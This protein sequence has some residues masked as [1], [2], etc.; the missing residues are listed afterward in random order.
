MSKEY[1]SYRFFIM[2]YV[3]VIGNF[4]LLISEGANYYIWFLTSIT[5]LGTLLIWESKKIYGLIKHPSQYKLS[6]E[7]IF[8]L[9]FI[10]AYPRHYQE[11][12]HL[13]Y[14]YIL[15]LQVINVLL[16]IMIYCIKYKSAEMGKKKA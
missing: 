11:Y 1:K 5:L 4:A 8:L 16:F 14:T 10:I 9:V 2:I 3:L 7:S 15:I 13:D 12:R 6:R